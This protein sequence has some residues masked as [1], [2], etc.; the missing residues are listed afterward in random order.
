[1]IDWADEMGVESVV[2]DAD[3]TIKGLRRDLM[4]GAVAYR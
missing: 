3:T 1:M 4:L 2:I